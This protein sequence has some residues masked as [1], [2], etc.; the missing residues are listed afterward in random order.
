VR[1]TE[2]DTISSIRFTRRL[3]FYAARK[4]R[5][6]A[7]TED[8]MQEGLLALLLLAPRFDPALG[9]PFTS[10]VRPRVRGAMF[11]YLEKTTPFGPA[12][13][14]IDESLRFDPQSELARDEARRL[15]F[16]AASFTLTEPQRDVF[17]LMARGEF[18]LRASAAALGVTESAV[19][20]IRQRIFSRLKK[21]LARQGI[22]SLSDIA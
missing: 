1:L 5:R 12:V 10:F 19:C 4:C 20:A 2:T 13:E 21:E 22:H 7:D 14:P 11:D 9:V 8:L 18:S 3:A 16:S 6:I 15:L 17:R